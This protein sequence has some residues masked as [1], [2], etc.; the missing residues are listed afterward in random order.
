MWLNKYTIAVIV[1]ILILG[2]YIYM[3]RNSRESMKKKRSKKKPVKRKQRRTKK[4]TLI[5]K[6]EEES[7]EEESSEDTP[8]ELPNKKQLR[9]DASELYDLVHEE[10]CK[11]MQQEAFEEITGDLANGMSFI[12]LKQLYNKCADQQM[13]P[14]KTITVQHY[15]DILK[16]TDE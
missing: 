2:V 15:I 3:S 10:L 11:G 13:D 5:S 4:S 1:A 12:E 7:S 6:P 8:K 16:K 14:M 9:D